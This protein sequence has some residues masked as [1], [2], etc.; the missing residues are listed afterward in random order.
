MAESLA[1]F[2]AGRS[3]ELRKLAEEHLE[4]EYVHT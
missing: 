4:H 1:A 3:A 2:R